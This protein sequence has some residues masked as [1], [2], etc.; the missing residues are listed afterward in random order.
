LGPGRYSVDAARGRV[1]SGWV[2]ALAAAIF[3]VASSTALL[4]SSYRPDEKPEDDD[5]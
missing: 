3:G 4:A 1:R 5:L 2:W